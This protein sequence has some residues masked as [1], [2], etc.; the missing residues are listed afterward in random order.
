MAGAG[1]NGRPAP[2]GA[3]VEE[4]Q[5]L[6]LWIAT[7]DARVVRVHRIAQRVV[8]ARESEAMSEADAAVIEVARASSLQRPWI[9]PE[10]VWEVRA[11]AALAEHRLPTRT[12]DAAFLASAVSLPLSSLGESLTTRRLAAAAV[13]IRAGVAIALPDDVG[14]QRDWAVSL[15][16]MGDLCLREGKP[17]EAR[18][19][20][21]QALGISERLASALPG[22]VQAQT[23]LATSHQRLSA[24]AEELG[25]SDGARAHL[26]Q[27]QEL[28]SRV[29]A[30]GL[31]LDSE[32]AGILRQLN[33]RLGR[34]NVSRLSVLRGRFTSLVEAERHE[35]AVTLLDELLP[36][37]RQTY[38]AGTE[39]LAGLLH[40][41]AGFYE[42]MDD[43]ARALDYA[44]E[45]IDESPGTGS[46]AFYSYVNTRAGLLE[47]LGRQVEA[48]RGFEFALAV[49]TQIHGAQSPI[50]AGARA[51][52]DRARGSPHPE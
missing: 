27:C 18:P 44:T 13:S 21:Q 48:V 7:D 30:Q 29:A 51:N 23:D 31:A 50:T 40:E 33:T 28:L 11:L 4:L 1:A 16:N 49:A 5:G 2:W 14:A 39:D 9:L 41:V 45:A 36:L 52:L 34:P 32:F 19:F 12:R 46:P 8:L 6:R 20:F 35:E 42:D 24:V 10:D 47:A 37:A 22:I 15:D 43:P 17:D 3:L 26:L 38:G 25:D